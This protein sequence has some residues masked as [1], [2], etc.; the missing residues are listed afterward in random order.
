MSRK[1]NR[2][3]GPAKPP[4]AVVPVPARASGEKVVRLRAITIGKGQG[5]PSLDVGRSKAK[6][7]TLRG[8]VGRDELVEPP[9]DH[10]DLA[11]LLT[12]STDFAT[13]VRQI[14]TDVAG[15]GW[16]LV[17]TAEGKRASRAQVER[18][19]AR[20]EAFFRDA[21]GG[22][23]GDETLESVL[24]CFIA[25]R[26]ATGNG[27][28]EVTRDPETNAPVGLF[29]LQS[30]RMFIR[31]DKAGYG[32]ISNANAREVVWFRPFGSEEDTGFV[33]DDGELD[34]W[35]DMQVEDLPAGDEFEYEP[36]SEVFHWRLYHPASYW[37]GVS[38]I[39]PAIGAVRGNTFAADR[40]LKFF[41]NKALPE[42]A[43]VLEGSTETLEEPDLEA[44]AAMLEDHF[45]TEMQGEHF[46]PLLLTLPSGIT[47]RVEKMSEPFKDA[48][49][50]AFQDANTHEILRAGG[51]MPNRV[52]IIDVANLGSG[53]GESQIEIYDESVV[54]PRQRDLN[55]IL[56]RI[57]REG[58]GITT[59]AFEF[60]RLDT[61]DE[62]AY[63]QILTMFCAAA[64]L[65]INEGREA[66]EPLLRKLG[67]S[68]PEIDEDWANLPFPVLVPGLATMAYAFAQIDPA[69]LER[70]LP[71]GHVGYRLADMIRRAREAGNGNG[72]A[73]DG[74]YARLQGKMGSYAGRRR[75]DR[76]ARKGRAA[77]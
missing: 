39:V 9:L 36:L 66:A 59:L 23:G 16:K 53:S 5:T 72:N 50:L 76:T 69:E 57:L 56:T 1:K 68:L 27:Y 60:E 75:A 31:K 61:A 62:L 24:G 15:R 38:W 2:R 28:L 64:L 8:R 32:Q 41:L 43:V 7:P 45:M 26:E 18:D 17:E 40:N 49:H 10:Q 25:D 63:A 71:E 13:V 46:K 74:A 12:E 67:I 22:P 11:D 20:A 35:G 33:T 37:Y 58:L 4:A 21:P 65:T 44:F 47:L 3:G 30:T 19:R 48:D 51:M 52:G 6:P 42:V 54:F 73:I 77:A 55:L 70:G 29:H 14:S 34:P